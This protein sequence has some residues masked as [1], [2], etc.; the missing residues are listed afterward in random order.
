MLEGTSLYDAYSFSNYDEI[1]SP[2]NKKELK[3]EKQNNVLPITK[4][5]ETYDIQREK[6]LYPR[7]NNMFINQKPEIIYKQEESY[8]SKL[9]SKKKDL[10]K[11]IQ[12]S[13]I[14]TLGLSI[15]Y[16]VSYYVDLYINTNDFSADRQFIIRIL[17][18]ISLI[19]II[20][21]MRLIKFY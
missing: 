14:I 21:N 1:K 13:L 2:I 9:I 11:I 7:Q 12:L 3:K 20:W 5:N 16:F 8:I 18:P 4:M 17:F 10:L 19:I 6:I 15:Y